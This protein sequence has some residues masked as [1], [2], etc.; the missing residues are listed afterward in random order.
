M[1]LDY[2]EQLNVSPLPLDERSAAVLGR[3][4]AA[5]IVAAGGPEQAARVAADAV[6]TRRAD[7]PPDEHHRLQRLYAQV[8]TRKELERLM[9]NGFDALGL[10]G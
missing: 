3:H 2:K 6:L 1:A 9:R 5:K 10:G 8:Y 4:F 7:E